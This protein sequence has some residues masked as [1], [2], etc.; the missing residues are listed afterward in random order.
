MR[1]AP[2][3]PADSVGSGPAG[4]PIAPEELIEALPDELVQLLAALDGQPPAV[5]AIALSALRFGSRTTLT[6]AGVLVEPGA[7]RGAVLTAFGERV[8]DACAQSPDPGA[9]ECRA[10]ERLMVER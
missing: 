10:G 5:V 8:A 6:R 9:A 4:G 2:A 1:S 3:T 7:G